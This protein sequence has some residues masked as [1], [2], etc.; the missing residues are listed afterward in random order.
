MPVLRSEYA[1]AKKVEHFSCGK[2][3][4]TLPA[5]VVGLRTAIFES[6]IPVASIRDAPVAV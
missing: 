3:A 5:I 1:Q 2:P 4:S 6:S